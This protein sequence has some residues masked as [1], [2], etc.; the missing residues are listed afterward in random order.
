MPASGK[1][2]L[3]KNVS[4]LKYMKL[5]NGDKIPDAK[6]VFLGKEHKEIH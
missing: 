6:I 2:F 1:H 5:K 3:K 4:R